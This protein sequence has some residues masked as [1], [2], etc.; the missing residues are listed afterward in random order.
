MIRLGAAKWLKYDLFFNTDSSRYS[1]YHPKYLIKSLWYF[2]QS[3]LIPHYHTLLFNLEKMSLLFCIVMFKSANFTSTTQYNNRI[4]RSTWNFFF[5]SHVV[6]FHSITMWR[7]T[8]SIFLKIYS[9]V[10]ADRW[11]PLCA[12]ITKL[13][14][15]ISE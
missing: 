6:L 3:I 10:D 13:P 2:S 4:M 8:A 7:M 5:A 11:I 15:K 9:I 14:K 1:S 12:K